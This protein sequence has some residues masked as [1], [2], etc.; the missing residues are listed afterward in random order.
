MA[1]DRCSQRAGCLPDPQCW[2]PSPVR[3][4]FLPRGQVEG[5]RMVLITSDAL[6]GVGEFHFR[7]SEV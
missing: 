5:G 7:A 3:K 6:Q 1:W 2:C 4:G